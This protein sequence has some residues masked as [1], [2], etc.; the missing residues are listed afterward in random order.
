MTSLDKSMSQPAAI[1]VDTVPRNDVRRGDMTDRTAAISRMAAM[2]QPILSALSSKLPG[3]VV[4]G[5]VLILWQ[6]VSVLG[7][8]DRAFLPPVT[9]VL[10]AWRRDVFQGDLMTYLDETL[11]HMMIGYAA[12]VAVGLTLGVLMGRSRLFY[13]LIEPLIEL[14]R[15]VPVPAFIPLLILFVGIEGSL[16][17]V[18]V[19]IGAVFPIV[20]STYAGVTSVPQTM[21]E[22]AQTFGLSHW[23]TVKE[24][25]IPNAAPIIS[26]GLRTSLAI[27]LI[28]ATVAEMISGTGGIGYYI[29]QAEQALRVPSIYAGILT[30]AIVGYALNLLFLS[31]DRL[32]LHWHISVRDQAIH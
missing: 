7:L 11:A 19:F 20:L 3:L 4:V 22:T 25:V 1:A 15:P 17:V 28:V 24:I 14:T 6:L 13:R 2:A 21:R 29:L 31:I 16:K 32:V 30:L 5:A 23:Q 27:S 9:A 8:V 26:V 10:V 12:A 18:V